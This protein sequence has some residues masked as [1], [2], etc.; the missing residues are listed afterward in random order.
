MIKMADAS[1]CATCA[2]RDLSFCGSLLRPTPPL[3]ENSLRQVHR[4]ERA[5]RDIYRANEMIGDAHIIC[6]GW[7]A[8]ISR[9]SDG[10]QQI[11]SF[12]IPGD[13]VSATAP[14]SEGLEFSVQ[15]VTEL[16]FSSVNRTNFVAALSRRPDLFDSLGGVFTAQQEEANQLIVNL[17]RRRADQ[18][19]ARLIL[20]LMERLA[21][22]GMV[23]DQSFSFPLNGKDLSNALG[24]APAGVKRVLDGFHKNKLIELADGI[25]KIVNLTEFQRLAYSR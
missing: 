7:A 10:R 6:H 9:L 16:R 25:L 14:F 3:P 11:L 2:V 12:L 23:K 13:L 22:R 17:G 21:A 24:L 19:I 15:T 1:P 8:R 20:H 5:R 4:S 18:R